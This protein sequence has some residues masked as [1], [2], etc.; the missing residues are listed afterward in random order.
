VHY[1]MDI[2]LY[3]DL[4]WIWIRSY[5]GMWIQNHGF[6]S[7]PEAHPLEPK[8]EGALTN[9]IQTHAEKEPWKRREVVENPSVTDTNWRKRGEWKIPT[10]K[11]LSSG[12]REKP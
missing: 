5:I 12:G 10:T 4:H 6:G 8:R 9:P 11:A 1:L 7:N 3:L 2:Y